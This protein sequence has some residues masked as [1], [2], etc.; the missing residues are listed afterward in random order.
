MKCAISSEPR[1][2]GLDML[3]EDCAHGK[4]DTEDLYTEAPD[5][6]IELNSKLIA[7]ESQLNEAV[8][9]LQKHCTLCAYG[10]PTREKDDQCIEC[11]TSVFISSIG[12]K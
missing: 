11:P 1:R 12:G 2:C 9:L 5:K 8:E 4:S 6:I 7:K 3:C 10:L